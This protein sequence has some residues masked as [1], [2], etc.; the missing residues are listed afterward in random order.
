ALPLTE[1]IGLLSTYCI[2]FVEDLKADV[3]KKEASKILKIQKFRNVSQIVID[4][5]GLESLKESGKVNWGGGG[6]GN[7]M[8]IFSIRATANKVSE[9]SSE[10][11]KSN[12][13]LTDQLNELNRYV[14]DEVEWQFEGDKIVPKSIS[15][16]KLA[17]GQF[18]GTMTFNRVRKQFYEAPF[19]RKFTLY[20]SSA[21]EEKSEIEIMKNC[22]QGYREQLEALG[23]ESVEKDNQLSLIVSNA[24]ARLAKLEQRVL[25]IDYLLNDSSENVQRAINNLNEALAAQRY[26]IVSGTWVISIKV[27]GYP[28][29]SR[30]GVFNKNFK[31]VPKIFYTIKALHVGNNVAALYKMT[32]E[33]ITTTQFTCDINF[34]G[35]FHA[36]ELEIEWIAYGLV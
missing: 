9:S 26:E 24:E 16:A 22:I 33:R 12:K 6:G 5:K 11:F 14:N 35:V 10:W 32:N 20:I 2:D 19:I 15:V 18:S 17:R 30:V 28:T 21:T 1:A 8:K 13:S 34:F 27:H 23:S 29:I 4:E 25:Y 7:F 31:K 36:L 3:I